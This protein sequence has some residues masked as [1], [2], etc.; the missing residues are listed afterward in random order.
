MVE[1]SNE[2]D[3]RT[4]G[5]EQAGGDSRFVEPLF[6]VVANDERTSSSSGSVEQ[7]KTQKNSG[8]EEL[9]YPIS[10]HSRR[11]RD[12]GPSSVRRPEETQRSLKTA[13]GLGN[14]IVVSF[15]YDKD[16]VVEVK[17]LIGRKWEPDGK[18][19]ICE[20]SADLQALLVKHSFVTDDFAKQ[21]LQ[22]ALPMNSVT[23]KDH[24]L[25]L[26][27]G[28]DPQLLE[29]IRS[30]PNRKWDKDARHWTFSIVAIPVL[31]KLAQDFGLSWNVAD[32]NIDKPH[33]VLDKGWL[34]VAFSA[35][36]D[37]QEVMAE[38][39]GTKW[40][41][42]QMRWLVPVEYAPEIKMVVD[43]HSFSTDNEV[44]QEFE[45]FGHEIELLTL[46][47]SQKAELDIPGLRIELM[48][49][50][51]AG[52]LYVLKALNAQQQSDKSWVLGLISS[53]DSDVQ[54]NK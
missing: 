36:R 29:E 12:Y 10:D 39:Y 13:E 14:K 19:W 34:S 9:G 6:N 51:Q 2:P 8:T 33:V 48:P 24:V 38:L 25:I 16:L 17:N 7:S 46:S 1:W 18:R 44:E 5:F 35:E 45:R 3:N 20:P 22:Q 52:V 40:D 43:K 31:A 37:V 47:K 15:P 23:Q 27:V 49:F 4:N 11:M 42:F 41:G 28:Y 53:K 54:S 32:E 50:Q 30:I 26:K 21:I